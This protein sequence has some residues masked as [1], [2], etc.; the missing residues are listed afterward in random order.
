[1]NFLANNL[2]PQPLWLWVLVTFLGGALVI[3]ITFIILS[4]KYKNKK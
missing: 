1:M 3:I 4:K 2:N